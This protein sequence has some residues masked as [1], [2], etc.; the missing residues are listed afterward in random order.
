[1]DLTAGSGQSV[2]LLGRYN[3]TGEGVGYLADMYS[4]P[5]L[6]SQVAVRIFRRNLDG[7]LSLLKSGASAD[8]SGTLEFS[9]KGSSLTLKMDGVTLLSATDTLYATGSAGVRLYGTPGAVY[10]DNFSVASL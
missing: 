8:S 6:S 2:G 10:L 5:A 1:V 7:S 3:G 4:D 9:L